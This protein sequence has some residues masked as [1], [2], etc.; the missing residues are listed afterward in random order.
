MRVLLAGR[1]PIL[2]E[3][4]AAALGHLGHLEFV[5]DDAIPVDVVLRTILEPD[6]C[7]TFDVATYGLVSGGTV[8]TL[9]AVQN[10]LR[11]W[12]DGPGGVGERILPGRMERLIDVLCALGGA[13]PNDL[14]SQSA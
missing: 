9:D 10:V 12:P 3:L 11:V 2:N 6:E 13:G 4:L 5:V 7:L 1:P 8:V 14:Y